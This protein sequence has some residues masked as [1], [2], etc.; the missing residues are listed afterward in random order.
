MIV[1]IDNNHWFWRTNVVLA[2]FCVSSQYYLVWK[3][4]NKKVTCGQIIFLIKS[5]KKKLYF[6]DICDPIY[7]CTYTTPWSHFLWDAWI[8][9]IPN[10]YSG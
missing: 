3:S 5:K 2:D 7:T 4:L 10:E 9:L 8:L 6:C 1:I